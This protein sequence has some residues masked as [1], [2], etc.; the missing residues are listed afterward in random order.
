M[1]LGKYQEAKDAFDECLS[2]R[3]RTVPEDHWLL[4]TTK[5][6]SVNAWSPSVMQFT[7]NR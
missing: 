3:L 5:A 4:V 6:F 2:I 1:L 7:E